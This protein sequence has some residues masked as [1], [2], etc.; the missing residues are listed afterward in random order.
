[1]RKKVT[2]TNFVAEGLLN[3]LRN[4]GSSKRING[5]LAYRLSKS[6]SALE[7]E[8]KDY[9]D[10][11]RAFFQEYVEQLAPNGTIAK[12]K[13]N[14]DKKKAKKAEEEMRKVQLEEINVEV[15][16]VAEN[17]LNQI[18]LTIAEAELI[19]KYLIDPETNEQDNTDGNIQS[20]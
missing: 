1:M 16:C 3:A 8:L 13:E 15:T 18:D 20:K 10:A 9:Q 6:T 2:M 12:F 5:L 4:A 17:E 11:Q 14:I 7:R 19:G